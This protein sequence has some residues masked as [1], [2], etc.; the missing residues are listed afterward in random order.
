MN[1][2]DL[3]WSCGVPKLL[4][5]CCGEEGKKSLEVRTWTSA[6]GGLNSCSGWDPSESHCIHFHCSCNKLTL[7]W[8]V[9]RMIV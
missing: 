4:R 8:I 2:S 3:I 7:T 5:R 9:P 6:R 1:G